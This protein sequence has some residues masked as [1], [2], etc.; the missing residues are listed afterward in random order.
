MLPTAKI[1]PFSNYVDATDSA[2]TKEIAT[3]YMGMQ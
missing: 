3:I 1:Y 2:R